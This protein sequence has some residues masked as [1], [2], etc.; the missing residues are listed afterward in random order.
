MIRRYKQS[1]I[2]AIL[3]LVPE[4]ISQ[5]IYKDVAIDNQKVTDTLVGNERNILFHG[6]VYELEG[7]IVGCLC[8]T[9]GTRFWTKEAFAFDQLFY[10]KESFRGMKAATELVVAYATWAKERKVRKAFLSNSMG[11]NVDTFDRLARSLGFD[12]VGTIH[13]MEIK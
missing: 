3:A 5:T 6:N 12:K 1:D 2:P 9:V 10:V 8:A 4:S 13:Q 7:Q 11:V